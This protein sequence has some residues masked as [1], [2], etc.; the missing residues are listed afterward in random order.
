V[1]YSS[2]M[3]AALLLQPRSFSSSGVIEFGDLLLAEADFPADFDADAATSHA[4]AGRLTLGEIERVA[5]CA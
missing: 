4:M 2:Q 1:R 5:E 3:R